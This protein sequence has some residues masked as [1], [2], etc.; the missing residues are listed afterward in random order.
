[1]N[2]HSNST[3]Y[4][5]SPVNCPSCYRESSLSSRN[6]DPAR[7]NR[8]DIQARFKILT[9]TRTTPL[10]PVPLPYG[11]NDIQWLNSFLF[12]VLKK[13]KFTFFDLMSWG[14]SEF[15]WP[16]DGTVAVVRGQLCIFSIFGL[17]TAFKLQALAYRVGPGPCL[18]DPPIACWRKRNFS[19]MG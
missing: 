17:D 7:P 11:E 4:P 16:A 9:G 12:W 1:M 5:Q 13:V 8:T 2:L 15:A 14:P 10:I 19:V 6:A 3:N 18:P